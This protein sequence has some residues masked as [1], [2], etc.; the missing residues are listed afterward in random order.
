MLRIHKD[1][2]QPATNSLF[3]IINLDDYKPKLYQQYIRM[4]ALNQTKLNQ[5][6]QR[7]LKALSTTVPPLLFRAYSLE[8]AKRTKGFC[9]PEFF[10]PPTDMNTNKYCYDSLFDMP[11]EEVK[12]MGGNHLMWKDRNDDQFISWS[13]SMLFAIEHALGRSRK[14][15]SQCYI[16]A[17]ET[18]QAQTTCTNTRKDEQKAEF[19]WATDVMNAYKIRDW[20]GWQN[21]D[22]SGLHPRKLTHEVLSVGVIQ[23][24]DHT[25]YNHVDLQDL[26]N[27]G[28]FKEYEFPAPWSVES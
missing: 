27:C 1:K 22:H 7:N 8:G 19:F 20:Q 13:R 24:N 18:S 9:S 14:G 5:A 10:R 21:F 2:R 4:S 3:D 28:L 6:D 25:K 15:Q 23:V 26:I 16:S 11:I 12:V 17:M